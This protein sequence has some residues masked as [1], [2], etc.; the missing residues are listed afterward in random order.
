MNTTSMKRT[1][2]LEES[3]AVLLRYGSWLASAAIGLG[4]ALALCDSWFGTRNL[5]ILPNMRIAA[6]GIVLFILLPTL[7]VLLMLL[8]FVHE[9]DFRLAATAGLVFAI[10]LLGIFLGLRAASGIAAHQSQHRATA[11]QEVSL[12]QGL[13][14]LAASTVEETIG[15]MRRRP[16]SRYSEGVIPSSLWNTVVIWDDLKSR[17]TWQ[18]RSSL[19]SAFRATLFVAAKSNEFLRNS[20]P[21]TVYPIGCEFARLGEWYRYWTL[22]P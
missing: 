15:V 3:L 21:L 6:I 20:A 16:L 11:R 5:A 1:R 13:R 12:H 10:I 22:R 2:R 19:H 4:F 17:R 8:A 18:Y 14:K 7:R 9:G